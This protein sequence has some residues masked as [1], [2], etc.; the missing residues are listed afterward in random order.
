MIDYRRDR[1]LIIALLALGSAMADP[2]LAK[3]LDLRGLEESQ[4]NSWQRTGTPLQL[5][6]LEDLAQAVKT[7]QSDQDDGEKTLAQG[8]VTHF[9]QNLGVVRDKKSTVRGH[10]VSIANQW[11]K[12]KRSI[13][14]GRNHFTPPFM[15]PTGSRTDVIKRME[16]YGFKDE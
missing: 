1:D 7:L 16:E 14:W 13:N 8:V 6:A 5:K 10:L 12:W 4:K 2:E 15:V 9:L 3:V 11:A